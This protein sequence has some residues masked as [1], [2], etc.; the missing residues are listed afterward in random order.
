MKSGKVKIYANSYIDVL[1]KAN[2]FDK[3]QT[4]SIFVRNKINYNIKKER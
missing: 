2:S 1:K 4:I 3:I